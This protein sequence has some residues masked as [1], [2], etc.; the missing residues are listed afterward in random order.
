MLWKVPQIDKL[1]Q[2]QAVR[3]ICWV[4]GP[5]ISLGIFLQVLVFQA[6]GPPSFG[7]G[8]FQPVFSSAN[9]NRSHQSTPVKDKAISA[10][11]CNQISLSAFRG[12]LQPTEAGKDPLAT[13][14]LT[15][16]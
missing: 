10:C 1:C 11:N 9:L 2:K 16:Q 5:F 6:S 4:A 12:R 15:L 8:V 13:W 7:G 3:F 14:F